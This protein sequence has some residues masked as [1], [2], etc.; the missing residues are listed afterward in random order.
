MTR[1]RSW[2]AER[3]TGNDHAQLSVGGRRFAARLAW[4]AYDVTLN[5]LT[6]FS[7]G[8]LAFPAL[9]LLPPT[10]LGAA[11]IAGLALVLRRPIRFAAWMRG[12]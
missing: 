12:R 2:L 6:V 7:L 8:Q 11:G 10:L 9:G 4:L 1:V 3:L 5:V